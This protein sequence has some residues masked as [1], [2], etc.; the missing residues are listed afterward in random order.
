MQLRSL[1]MGYSSILSIRS[2]SV[3][4]LAVLVNNNLLR[5]ILVKNNYISYK[6][7]LGEGS[8]GRTGLGTGAGASRRRRGGGGKT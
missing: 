8:I 2:F 5:K 6:V 7:V 3:L 4:L 1:L